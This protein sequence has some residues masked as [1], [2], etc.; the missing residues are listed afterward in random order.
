MEKKIFKLL[1]ILIVCVSVF[2]SCD[3]DAEGALYNSENKVDVAFASTQLNVDMV[4]SDNGKIKVAVY[5][6]NSSTAVSVPV[7]LDAK[8]LEGGIFVLENSKVEFKA[9]EN[10]AYAV[11]NYGNFDKISPT[12]QYS[13]ILSIADSTQLSPSEINKITI[14]TQR[15][16]TWKSIGSSHYYSSLFGDWDQPIEKADEGNIYRLPD[17]ITKDYPL[18]FALTDD[19]Q[20]LASYAIQPTGYK[21]ATYGM[22]YYV[23]KAFSRDGNRL[24]FQFKPCVIYNRKYAQLFDTTQDY[25]DLP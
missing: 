2:T 19:G 11:L 8:T 12:S 25:I 10:I 1:V 15:K 24:N 20:D 13:I 3:T 5:R 16:L 6:G 4:T 9:G 23:I 22:V 18:I 17:C 21:N 14:K 7:T